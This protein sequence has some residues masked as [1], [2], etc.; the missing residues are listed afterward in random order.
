VAAVAPP[1]LSES[2]PLVVSDVKRLEG[3]RNVYLASLEKGVEESPDDFAQRNH[4]AITYAMRKMYDKA[5][6]QLNAV[7]ERD[8]NNAAAYNNLG[9]IY[10]RQEQVAQATQ[11]Y[12]RARTIDAEDPGIQINQGLAYKIQGDNAKGDQILA[13]A[14]SKAGGYEQSSDLIGLTTAEEGRGAATRL[15]PNQLRTLFANLASDGKSAQT[16]TT[17]ASEADGEEEFFMYWKE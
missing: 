4:L 10:S 9:N 16:I 7:I 15:V 5:I 3:K 1:M 14:I 6:A 11:A 13:T 17:R 12:E 8:P 2:T